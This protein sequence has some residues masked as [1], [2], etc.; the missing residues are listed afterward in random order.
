VGTEKSILSKS[1]T[2]AYYL[3]FSSLCSCKTILSTDPASRYN[4]EFI[5]KNSLKIDKSKKKH[6]KIIEQKKNSEKKKVIN[7]NSR[8]ST[9]GEKQPLARRENMSISDPKDSIEYNY[10]NSLYYR[11]RK[12][13]DTTENPADSSSENMSYL[14]S[15]YGEYSQSKTDFLKIEPSTSTLHGDLKKREKN[16]ATISNLNL[17]RCFDYLDIMNRIKMKKYLHYKRTEPQ[18]KN[19]EE[20]KQISSTKKKIFEIFKKI[21]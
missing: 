12:L 17:Q 9:N 20:E 16:Q 7:D 11:H 8:P 21:K 1:R 15:N 10:S 19:P 13:K 5:S 4:N 6:H 2:V 3:I 14:N 18:K